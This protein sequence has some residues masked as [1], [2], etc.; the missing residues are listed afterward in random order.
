MYLFGELVFPECFG[1][2]F[3]FLLLTDW[4]LLYLGSCCW[5]FLILSFNGGN[6]RVGFGVWW[7][8]L[9]LRFGCFPW[10]ALRFVIGF[11]YY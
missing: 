2:D 5:V 6:W 11:G 1:C 9:I 8:V 7:L 10:Y 4:L 3:S